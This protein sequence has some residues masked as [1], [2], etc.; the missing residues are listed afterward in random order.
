[1]YMEDRTGI[2]AILVVLGL[3]VLYVG[4]VNVNTAFTTDTVGCNEHE[5]FGPQIA[6]NGGIVYSKGPC[7]EYL[8]EWQTYTASLIFGILFLGFGGYRIFT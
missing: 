1:M 7:T 6:E 4:L 2:G 3:F 8:Y 5:K